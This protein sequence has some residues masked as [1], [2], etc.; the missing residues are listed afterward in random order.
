VRPVKLGAL[1]TV[2][3]NSPSYMMLLTDLD[4]IRT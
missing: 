3:E 1:A 2:Q 4:E